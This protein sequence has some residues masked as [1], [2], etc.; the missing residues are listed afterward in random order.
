M[1][2]LK[3]FAQVLLAESYPRDAKRSQIVVPSNHEKGHGAASLASVAE[4]KLMH[5]EKC[6]PPWRWASP[7]L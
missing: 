6:A 1:R 7:T 2:P 5:H 3:V 4:R